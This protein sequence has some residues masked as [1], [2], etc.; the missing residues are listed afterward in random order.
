MVSDDVARTS[1]QRLGGRWAISPRGFFWA[2]VISLIGISSDVRRLGYPDGLLFLA[3]TFAVY[4]LNGAIDVVLHRTRWSKRRVVPVPAIE[5]LA[6]LMFSGLCLATVYGL[7]RTEWGVDMPVG[8]AEGFVL[9]PAISMWV[10]SSLIILLDVIDQAR[11]VRIQSIEARARSLDI[12]TRADATIQKVRQRID[13]TLSPEMNRLRGVVST[14]R[15]GVVSSEIRAVV[16]RSVR[17][18]GRRLWR[19]AEGTVGRISLFEVIRSLI[20]HPVLRPWPMIGLAI[21]IPL[22]EQGQNIDVRILLVAA[23]AV[24]AVLA[25]CWVANTVMSRHPRLRSLVILVVVCVF[26]AQTLMV[27]QLGERWGQSPDDPGAVTVFLLTL[28]LIV[29]TSAFG[30]YRALNDE[31]AHEIA[32]DIAAEKLDAEAHAHAVSE[33]TRR[34]AALLHGRVQSRLLG[35]AMAIEFAGDDPDALRIALNRT[36]DVLD[37]DWIDIDTPVDHGL[38]E[39]IK[40]WSG[41]AEI[42][43]DI[44]LDD[45]TAITS[46]VVAVVEELLANA[47]R[48]GRATRVDVGIRTIDND[49][50][51]TVRDNGAGGDV[52]RSGLGSQLLSRLGIVER[53]PAADG[54]NVTVRV[55]Q[56]D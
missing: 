48:H 45:D 49:V 56:R 18:V 39:V 20:L 10:G 51:V 44:G 50:V 32:H 35:C 47:V 17:G 40:P 14:E 31:R 37:D 41:L 8:L 5:V 52:N 55:T 1:R 19:S 6:R 36:L 13:T 15:H 21:V 27:D 29:V 42:H 53:V 11:Q 28:S 46:D 23:V 38:T 12:V 25:E 33:E 26:T 3:G 43:L 7:L 16:D 24:I 54:W 9:Y 4:G 30:S 2:L 34:L 22:F